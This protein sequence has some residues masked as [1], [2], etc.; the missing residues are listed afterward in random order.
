MTFDPARLFASLA[1][2]G[3]TQ[4]AVYQPLQGPRAS[5]EAGFVQPDLEVDDLAQSAE[6][7][8]EYETARAPDLA[9]GARVTLCGV[10]YVLREAPRRR[11][12]GFYSTAALTKVAA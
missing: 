7:V 5:F 4:T 12:D 10:E 9:I 3:L 1:R 6:T 8:I 11:G 2:H